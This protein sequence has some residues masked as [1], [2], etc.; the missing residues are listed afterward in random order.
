MPNKLMDPLG[1]LMGL[2]Y[3]S[4]PETAY[5]PGPHQDIAM[6]YLLLG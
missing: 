2:R 1:K 4:H 5:G 6:G 3:K